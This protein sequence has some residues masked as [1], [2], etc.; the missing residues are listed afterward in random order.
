[1]TAATSGRSLR[2]QRLLL[3]HRR[4]DQHVVRRQVLAARVAQVHVC[5]VLR[6]GAELVSDELLRRRVLEEVVGR[7]EEESL[8]RIARPPEARN[9][10]L[11]RGCLQIRLRRQPRPH[12][13]LAQRDLVHRGD[14]LGHVTAREAFRE[15]DPERLRRRRRWRGRR[16][17]RAS[18]AHDCD[19]AQ[20]DRADNDERHDQRDRAP[21]RD[22]PRRYR[23]ALLDH[24]R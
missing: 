12:A 14:P 7:R 23:R 8:E 2:R 22:P 20:R 4:D 6:E 1:M 18:R 15:D 9:A 10:H 16:R 24:S 17:R 3:D 11:P 19:D 5:P 13:A 21:H